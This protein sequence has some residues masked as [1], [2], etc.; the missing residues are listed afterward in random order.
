[1][2]CIINY[3]YKDNSIIVCG[4]EKITEKDETITKYYRKEYPSYIKD[5]LLKFGIT[6][7]EDF[8]KW[9]SER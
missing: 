8:Y 6:I 4:E 2:V 7:E 1:M 3:I 5:K 9:C